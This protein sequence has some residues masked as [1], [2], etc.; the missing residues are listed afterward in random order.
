MSPLKLRAEDAEDFAVIAACL[1]DAIVPLSDMQF[2]AAEKSF[3]LVANRFLWENCPESFDVPQTA[4]TDPALG[5]CG[6][7]ERVNCGLRFEGVER[8][9]RRGLDPKDRGRILELL[10]I[11][12]EPGA[13]TMLFAGG[14][15]LRLEGE[16]IVA[17]IHDMG[18]PWPTQWRP[19][20]VTGTP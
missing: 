1:Q 2:L 4:N 16:H 14:D 10:H 8:V 19:R 5:P 20:H 13:L 6:A 12:V 7:Y 11:E 17:F 9:R 15:A 3:A 18:E